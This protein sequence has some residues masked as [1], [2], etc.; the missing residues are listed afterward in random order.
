M[1]IKR[2]RLH[3]HDGK[4][5]I[6]EGTSIRNAFIN[7]GYGYGAIQALDYFEEVKKSDGQTKND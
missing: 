4:T 6:V 3:W 5:E 7:A 1:R 2:F